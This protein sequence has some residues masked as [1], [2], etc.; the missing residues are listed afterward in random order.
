MAENLRM[1]NTMFIILYIDEKIKEN[2]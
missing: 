1:I 2:F